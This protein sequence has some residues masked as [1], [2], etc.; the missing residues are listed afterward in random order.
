MKI[1]KTINT[2]ITITVL[3]IL[4]FLVIRC[5][6]STG[7][8]EPSEDAAGV[9]SGNYLINERGKEYPT[10]STKTS[11]LVNAQ[12]KQQID[13]WTEESANFPW[14]FSNVEVSRIGKGNFI[15]KKLIEVRGRVM[16]LKGTIRDGKLNYVVEY[17]VGK[18]SG[19]LTVEGL[20]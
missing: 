15:F 12:N 11:V 3:S 13:I 1:M 5:K 17:S 20:K 8:I 19:T 18:G 9:Y 14:Q 2:I 4:F 10:V 6:E 16:Y 7:N